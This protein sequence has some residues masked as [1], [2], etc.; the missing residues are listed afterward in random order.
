[1]RPYFIPFSEF[2]TSA[3]AAYGHNIM[4]LIPY[5]RG[6]TNSTPR[7]KRGEHNWWTHGWGEGSDNC[8]L[9]PTLGSKSMASA[10][11]TSL[12]PPPQP[13]TNRRRLPHRLWHHPRQSYHESG[14]SARYP[15]S[16][17][18]IH[19][20]TSNTMITD[21]T[22]K[23]GPTDLDS[24]GVLTR[25]GTWSSGKGAVGEAVVGDAVSIAVGRKGRREGQWK[26]KVGEVLIVGMFLLKTNAVSL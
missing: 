17:P 22:A 5:W 19:D 13:R 4:Y 18:K 20:R 21:I 24:C 10:A 23:K 3:T 25:T 15:H 26:E 7:T 16:R 6:W 11:L 9:S 2:I 14:P 12:C 1:M 8:L